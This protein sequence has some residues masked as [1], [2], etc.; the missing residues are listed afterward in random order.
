MVYAANASTDFKSSH[1]LTMSPVES[2]NPRDSYNAISFG[3]VGSNYLDIAYY[4]R[5]FPASPTN[6]VATQLRGGG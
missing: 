3:A 5:P 2:V 1:I 6:L 4:A